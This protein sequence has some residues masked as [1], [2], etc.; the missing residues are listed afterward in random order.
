MQAQSSDSN[1]STTPEITTQ[2]AGSKI[3]NQMLESTLEHRS[4]SLTNDE[5]TQLQKV[6]REFESSPHTFEEFVIALV[7]AFLLN[8]FPATVS[9]MEY[10]KQVSLSIA[11]S[12]CGDPLSRQ[13][14]LE[15]QQQLRG[16]DCG[17]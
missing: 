1:G 11:Q 3:L 4:R 14:L 16:I 7:S 8:R 2:E 5:W 12:F 15:F 9:N 13:R 6:A 17:N 10:L